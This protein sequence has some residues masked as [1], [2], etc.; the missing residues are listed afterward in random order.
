MIADWNGLNGLIGSALRCA[1]EAPNSV[2]AKVKRRETKLLN[3]ALPH[4]IFDLGAALRDGLR[5]PANGHK[6]REARPQ[7]N[8]HERSRQDQA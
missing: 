3:A 5:D 7:S 6:V 4:R 2:V 1:A 8:G